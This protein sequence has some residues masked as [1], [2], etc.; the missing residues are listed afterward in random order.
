[1]PLG[2]FV[3]PGTLPKPR[4]IART[5][6]LIFGVAALY[7]LAWL[8]GERDSLINTSGIDVGL[9]AGVVFALYY[10]PDLFVVGL[11]RPRGRR[12]QAAALVIAIVLLAVDFAAYGSGWAPPLGWG[13][14]L[15]TTFF[16]GMIGAAFLLA[17]ALAVPG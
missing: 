4:S 12:P 16:Y 7:Y 11:T 2:D 8:V 3:A 9:W 17:A 5:G 15:F 14:F 6:R 1:M 10:L 13:V